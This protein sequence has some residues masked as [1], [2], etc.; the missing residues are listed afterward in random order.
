MSSL[1]PSDKP[2][3]FRGLILTALALFVMC[4]T[5]VKL[6]NKKFASHTASAAPAAKH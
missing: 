5:I 3:A 1:Q 2:A 4:F 6:T